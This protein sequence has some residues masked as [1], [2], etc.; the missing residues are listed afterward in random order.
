MAGGSLGVNPP[1]ANIHITQHTSDWLWAVF[2]I[3]LLTDLIFIFWS[4]RRPRGQRLFHQIPI[5]ILTVGAIAYYSMASDLGATPVQVEWARAG[6]FGTRQIWFVRY[7]Q[8][9]INAPLLLLL[10]FLASGLAPGDIAVAMFMIDVTVIMGLVGALTPTRYKW[11]YFVFGVAS[12]IYVWWAFLGHGRTSNFSAGA[13][14]RTNFLAG[15]SFLSFI[16]LLYPVAWALSEGS[17]R[18]GPTGEMIWYGILDLCAAPLFLLFHTWRLRNV[19]YNT[20][21]LSSGKP[22]DYGRV[23]GDT[24]RG[25]GGGVTGAT[26]PGVGG[27]GVGNTGVGGANVG[28]AN[29]V[30]APGGAA[31]V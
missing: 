12:L 21:G 27:H 23:S 31:R 14:V 8:W 3:F 25:S 18:I 7:I 6:R 29:G 16:F 5:I 10:L 19:E 22:T 30:G 20:F 17:N 28:T 9:F 1:N 26:G 11:G 13:P 4:L 2:A 24:M 15:S